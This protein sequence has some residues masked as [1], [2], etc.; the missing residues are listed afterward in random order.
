MNQPTSEK[1]P[2]AVGTDPL[3]Q[4]GT[5]PIEPGPPVALPR[6]PRVPALAFPGRADQDQIPTQPE[7]DVPL[8]Y[9]AGDEALALE[10]PR[11]ELE[12]DTIPSPPPARD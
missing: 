9:S 2:A 7:H 8:T 10:M 5:R 1:K 4:S 3:K 12:R 6:A 11:E